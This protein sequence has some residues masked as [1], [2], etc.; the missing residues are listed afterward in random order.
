MSEMHYPPKEQIEGLSRLLIFLSND[1]IFW[2]EIWISGD[3]IK[4]KTES[5]KGGSHTRIFYIEESGK[6]EDNEFPY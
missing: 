6:V 2:H 5:Y 1:K 4:V 3:I